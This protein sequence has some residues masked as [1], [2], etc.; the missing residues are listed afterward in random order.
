MS[1][2]TVLDPEVVESLRQLTPPGEPDVLREI[3]TLFLDE[4]PK[5]IAALRAAMIAGDTVKVQRTA[6]SLKGSSGNIGARAMYD[7]CTQLDDRAKAGELGRLQAL[8]DA[9]DAEYRK[10]EMEIGRLMREP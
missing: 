7:I 2:H 10:V 5:K 3:F 1:A 8:V 4:V 6:H 9:L